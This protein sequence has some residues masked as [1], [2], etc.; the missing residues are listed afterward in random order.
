MW[1]EQFTQQEYE[2]RISLL[3][4]DSYNIVQELREK[5]QNFWSTFPVK[6]HHVHRNN[7]VTGDYVYYSKNTYDSFYTNN[8]E[9]SR[10]LSFMTMGDTKDCYDICE[11]G[12]NLELSYEGITVGDETQKA[13][14]CFGTWK[15]AYNTEYCMMTPG[16]RNCFGCCNMKKAEYCILNKQYSK[17]EYFKLRDIIISDMNKNP[18]VDKKG[19][20]FIYGEFFP[21][22]LSMFDYNESWA[23]DYFPLDKD[24]ALAQGFSWKDIEKN[25]HKITLQ[26]KDIPDSIHDIADAIL[27][28]VLGCDTCENVYRVVAAELQLLR[29]FGLPI[30]RQ[31]SSC[32]HTERLS[33]INSPRLYKRTTEDGV[34]VMTAYAPDRPE[35]IYSEEGYNNLIN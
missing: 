35:K 28:E 5:A 14:F 1:N 30:P 10:F 25:K 18:Y 27:Q 19:R 21:Y 8:A 15:G 33:R 2:E 26:A 9:D 23:V 17:E 4:L 13:K 7:S 22:E 16:S 34:E 3:Q 20:V 31:C 12:S 11:W 6:Y 29:R 32:R 24:S